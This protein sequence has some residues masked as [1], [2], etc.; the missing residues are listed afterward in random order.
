MREEIDIKILALSVYFTT[1]IQG[2]CEV[3]R[4]VLQPFR[5]STADET[6]AGLAR[7]ASI[8]T[9]RY[10]CAMKAKPTHH[11][12]GIWRARA[13]RRSALTIKVTPPAFRVSS[14]NTDSHTLELLNSATVG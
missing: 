14:P 7:E 4:L 13:G 11:L 3:C 8:S 10:S 2:L 6:G 9:P 1:T 12:T 5:A